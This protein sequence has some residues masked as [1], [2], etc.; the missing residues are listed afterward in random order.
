MLRH[1]TKVERFATIWLWCG[2][3]VLF[4]MILHRSEESKARIGEDLS[5]WTVWWVI[6]FPPTSGALRSS[7][8]K[9]FDNIQKLPARGMNAET[10]SIESEARASCGWQYETLLLDNDSFQLSF[11]SLPCHT[12]TTIQMPWAVNCQG[13]RNCSEKSARTHAFHHSFGCRTQ[14]LSLRTLRRDWHSIN[15]A[16]VTQPAIGLCFCILLS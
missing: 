11:V 6:V 7:H 5:L 8:T 2:I 12:S 3:F 4:K 1:M 16:H 9:A 13:S 10:S 15:T 14:I